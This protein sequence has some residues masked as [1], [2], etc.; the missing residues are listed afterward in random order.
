MSEHNLK[1]FPTAFEAHN[2]HSA[3]NNE[4]WLGS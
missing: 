1:K 4:H 2:D 3:T